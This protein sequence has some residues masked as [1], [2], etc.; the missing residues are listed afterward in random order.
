MAK[1]P[2]DGFWMHIN[3]ETKEWFGGYINHCCMCNKEMKYSE[4]YPT[5]D[6]GSAP[7]ILTFI[8]KASMDSHKYFCSYDCFENWIDKFVVN[9]YKE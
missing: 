8:E 9:S 3:V 5:T 1:N 4:N 6:E 7:L 2:Y